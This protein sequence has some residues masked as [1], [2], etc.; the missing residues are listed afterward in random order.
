MQQYAFRLYRTVPGLRRASWRADRIEQKPQVV[1]QL[2]M[3]EE[4]EHFQSSVSMQAYRRQ[5]QKLLLQERRG[6]RI[7]S[8][9]LCNLDSGLHDAAVEQVK[10]NPCRV[11]VARSIR[12]PQRKEPDFCR[13]ARALFDPGNAKAQTIQDRPRVRARPW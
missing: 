13:Q 12:R 1:F 6:E 9:A 2:K 5:A 11:V 3:L 7:G 10:T 4:L 8:I